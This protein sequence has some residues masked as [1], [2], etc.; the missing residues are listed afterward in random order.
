[1]D[2]IAVTETLIFTPGGSTEMC[3]S[4][5]ILDDSVDENSEFFTCIITVGGLQQDLV[6]ITI[7]DNESKYLHEHITEYSADFNICIRSRSTDRAR[8]AILYYY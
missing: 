7:I 8:A 4:V 2:Y 1:M 5:T 6:Q 3:V